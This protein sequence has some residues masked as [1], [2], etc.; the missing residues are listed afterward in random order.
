MVMALAGAFPGLPPLSRAVADNGVQQDGQGKYAELTADWWQWIYGQPVSSNPELDQTGAFAGAGQP[1]GGAYFLC[2]AIAVNATTPFY[3][4]VTRTITV[5]AGQAL[6]FPILN[7]ESSNADTPPGG[8]TVPQLRALNASV[9]DTATGMYATLDG[10]S[11]AGS[12]ARIKSPVFAYTLPNVAPPD[13]NLLQFFGLNLTGTVR[14]TVADGYWVYLDPL[15]K[16]AAPYTLTFGGS[17]PNAPF[18]LAITYYI[19]IK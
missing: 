7:V 6:F 2:G 9:V 8:Y 15:P 12:I 18:T 3:A 11:I 5:P 4:T 17:F 16:R 14:N 1:G 13:E 10:N 19:T